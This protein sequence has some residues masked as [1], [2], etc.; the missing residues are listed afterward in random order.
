MNFEQWRHNMR[1][2][3]FHFIGNETRAYDEYVIAYRHNPTAEAAR[4]LGGIKAKRGMSADAAY[5]L[6]EA[7]RLEP[8]HAETWFNLGFVRERSGQLSES[9]EAFR[10]SVRLKPMIDR[11]WYGMGMAYAALGNHVE[12]MKALEEAARLQPLNAEARYQ[13]GMACFHCGDLKRTRAAIME[14]KN[15]DS[16]RANKLIKDTGSNKF[17]DLIT[18]LPF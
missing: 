5:W 13:L 9:I 12:A 11:A 7:L 17:D 18:Q 3:L 2:W 16:K 10:E 4:S 1:A 15:M 6:E 14:L 8:E